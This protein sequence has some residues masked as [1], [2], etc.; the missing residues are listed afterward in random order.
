MWLV[1]R[2]TVGLRGVCIG[3]GLFGLAGLVGVSLG[4]GLAGV[5]TAAGLASL[6]WLV[7]F[8]AQRERTLYVESGAALAE[9]RRL[10][11][12]LAPAEAGSPDPRWDGRDELLDYVAGGSDGY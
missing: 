5:V 2:I 9:R 6:M 12:Y 4:S 1:L 11:S 8:A 10:G 7:P 3:V